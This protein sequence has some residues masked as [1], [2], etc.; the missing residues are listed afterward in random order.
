MNASD[1]GMYLSQIDVDFEIRFK[2]WA[3]CGLPLAQRIELGEILLNS[4][5]EKEKVFHR[6]LVIKIE[7][8]LKT[9]RL[10]LPHPN[11]K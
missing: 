7:N 1:M 11:S 5:A 9:W 8:R 6:Q 10:C 2:E 3:N 4:I